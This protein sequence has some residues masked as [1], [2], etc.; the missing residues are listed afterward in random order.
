MVINEE[1]KAELINIIYNI[2]VNEDMDLIKKY[3]SIYTDFSRIVKNASNV[4][5]RKISKTVRKFANFN[6]NNQSSQEERE[7]IIKEIISMGIVS[8]YRYN[9]YF[10]LEELFLR[11]M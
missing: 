3:G 2:W 8:I 1:E 7:K 10:E 6:E 9:K 4:T 11:R 5:S